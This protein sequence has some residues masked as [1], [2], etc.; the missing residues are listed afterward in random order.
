MPRHQD[1]SLLRSNLEAGEDEWRWHGRS[2]VGAPP[3]KP[4]R[5]SVD[6]FVGIPA[7]APPDPCR[8]EVKVERHGLHRETSQ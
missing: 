2:L 3:L 7:Q 6:L 1:A 4:S 5:W 8:L